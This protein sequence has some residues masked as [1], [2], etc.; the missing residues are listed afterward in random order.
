MSYTVILIALIITIK[1]DRRNRAFKG[2]IAIVQQTQITDEKGQIL[3]YS[4]ADVSQEDMLAGAGSHGLGLV[5]GAGAA[6]SNPS[7]YS[8][9]CP[10]STCICGAEP[11]SFEFSVLICQLIPAD[12]GSNPGTARRV[13]Q[14]WL[15]NIHVSVEISLTVL[16]L[17][18]WCTG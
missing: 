18:P 12:F 2:W 9:V 8:W 16:A 10:E 15:F 7:L 1:S 14:Y 13:M 5:L 11:N 17:A 3:W 6:I 4:K